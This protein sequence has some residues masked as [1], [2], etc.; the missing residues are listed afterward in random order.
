MFT[1][2]SQNFKINTHSTA[3]GLPRVIDAP[4]AIRVS[5]GSMPTTR[6]VFPVTTRTATPNECAR[7]GKAGQARLAYLNENG[8]L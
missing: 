1:T 3:T 6:R 7:F 5:K 8:M 4:K 2:Q